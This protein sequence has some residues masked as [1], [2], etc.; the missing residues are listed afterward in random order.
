MTTSPWKWIGQPFP[1][2][3]DKRFVLGKGRYVNDVVLSGMLHLA[4]VPSPH[5]HAAI[6]R[7][8]TSKA[9]RAPG[10]SSRR[11]PAAAARSWR[12]RLQRLGIR[13]QYPLLRKPCCR[14]RGIR[15]PLKSPTCGRSPLAR[16][17]V[18]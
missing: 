9:E 14:V 6:I 1:P 17:A 4:T 10:A 13:Q 2:V 16:P 7:I 18:R 15:P 5:A 12:W 11:S 8:D 3:E